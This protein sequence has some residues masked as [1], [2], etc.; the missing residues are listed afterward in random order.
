MEK[1]KTHIRPVLLQQMVV[2]VEQEETEEM[3]AQELQTLGVLVQL[4][5]REVQGELLLEEV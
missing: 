5:L 4:E 2:W 3:V 1:F